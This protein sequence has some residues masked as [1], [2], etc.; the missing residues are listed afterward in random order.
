MEHYDF[1]LLEVATSMFKGVLYYQHTIFISNQAGMC[2]VSGF[3]EWGKRE[4]V[5]TYQQT[6]SYVENLIQSYF[7]YPN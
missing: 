6:S 7:F 5:I 1:F 3:L 2:I 4:K